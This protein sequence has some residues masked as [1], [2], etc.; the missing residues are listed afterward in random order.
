MKNLPLLFLGIFFTL[1]FSW[2]GLILTS[3]LNLGGLGPTTSTLEDDGKLIAGEQLYPLKLGGIAKTGKQIYID[4]GCMY[5]HTQQ[6]RPKGFG[7]DYERGW[8]DR[9]TVAR[10]YI[11]QERVMLGTMRTGPDLAN[12]GSRLSS[13]EWHYNHLYHPR[14][15]SPGSIMPPYP[16][17]FEVR[18]IDGVRSA[19]AL[20]IPEVSAY[21]PPA[22]YEVIPTDRAR[23]LVAYLLALKVNYELP[24]MK[25]S[26]IE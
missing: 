25:F 5:C 26:E 20:N 18:K 8:G 6:I 21:A 13:E 17:L 1:A 14:I 19:D 4:Q 11:F 2:T 7:A 24:E 15:T 10:D 16:H 3:H 23:A 9:Q 22:G 12:V